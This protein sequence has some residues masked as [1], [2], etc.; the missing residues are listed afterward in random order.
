MCRRTSALPVTT[1]FAAMEH[2][3]VLNSIN[4]TLKRRYFERSY[5]EQKYV[6]CRIVVYVHIPSTGHILTQSSTN[7][8]FASRRRQ[9]S[10]SACSKS[11]LTTFASSWSSICPNFTSMFRSKSVGSIFYNIRQFSKLYCTLLICELM[12][13]VILNNPAEWL[14]WCYLLELSSGWLRC[15]DAFEIS[16]RSLNHGTEEVTS[17]TTSEKR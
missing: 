8:M 1:T 16:I 13:A 11:Y 6:Y 9:S 17:N 10:G 2:F 4:A 12:A 7:K 14:C 15:L 3:D 5:C